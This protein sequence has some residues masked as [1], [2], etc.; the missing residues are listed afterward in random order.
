VPCFVAAALNPRMHYAYI[1]SATV[2]QDL[3]QAFE[4][5]TNIEMVAATLLEV[6]MYRCKSSEFGR[7][8][9]RKMVMDGKSW[10]GMF[11]IMQLSKVRMLSTYSKLK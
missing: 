7:P 1:A 3:R 10:L 8:L 9:A 5:M 4:R 6:E 2:F 11:Q